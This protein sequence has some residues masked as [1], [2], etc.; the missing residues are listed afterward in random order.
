[1]QE[2]DIAQVAR[3]SGVPAS[4]LRYYE[5]RGLIRS[6]GRQGLR[7]IF[8]ES[9][10]D[11]LALITLGRS[12]GYSLDEIGGMFGADGR[13]DIDRERLSAKADE[14]DQT[15]ARLTAMRDG[16]R[17]LPAGAAERAPADALD[18]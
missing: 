3:R 2:L 4:T 15:I 8:A 16:L 6:M 1:M 5:E 14:L 17:H 7:R 13:L 12:V 11:T 9:V 10:I 18:E